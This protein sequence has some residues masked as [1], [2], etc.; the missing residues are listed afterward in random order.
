MLNDYWE[1][2][3]L[4]LKE[5]IGKG[6]ITTNILLPQDK[7][8]RGKIIAKDNFIL[9][10]VDFAKEVFKV[11]NKNIKFEKKFKDGE[12]IVK[13]QIIAE[14]EGSAKAILAGERTA[15]NIIQRLSAITTK[16]R[17]FVDRVK[18]YNVEILDTRKTT[19]NFRLFEK[20]AVKVGGGKNHRLGLYN[21]ILIKDNHI[22]MLGSAKEAVKRCKMKDAGCKIEIEVKTL[23]QLK[24]VLLLK[25]DIILLDNMSL[26]E[27]TL[28]KKIIGGLSKIE[29]SGG[30]NLKNVEKI[31]TV[32]VDYISVGE[33]THT[34]RA[35]DIHLEVL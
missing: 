13:K 30:V 21:G 11:L 6:D 20:Y 15:L 18:K 24:E 22:A 26:K 10:G 19:P 12:W 3:K 14:V 31:A 9:C 16:T 8:I 2:L 23:E 27:I 29:V 5:D 33:L 7:K 4:A 28:A 35:V 1:Y 17:K 25:P 34:T 32:G